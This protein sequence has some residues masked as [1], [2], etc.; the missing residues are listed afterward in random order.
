MKTRIACLHLFIPDISNI[1]K[2]IFHWDGQFAHFRGIY[3][4]YRALSTEMVRYGDG[5]RHLSEPG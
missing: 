5:L 3:F 1:Q 2:P 4:F